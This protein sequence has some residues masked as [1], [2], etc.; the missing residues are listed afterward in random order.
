MLNYIQY[1]NFPTKIACIFVGVFLFMQVIG[2]LLEFKG[3]VVPECIKVRKYFA[4][5]KSERE[6]LQKIPAMFN[7]VETLL[8][9]VGSHYSSDNIS[10]RD[11]WI[12]S[13]NCKMDKNDRLIR[14]LT[15]KIDKNNADT[16]ALLIDSKRN[17]IIDFAARVVDE[18]APV[19]HEQFHRIFK[20]HKEYETIISDNG[21]TNGEVD[22]AYR[23]ISESYEKHLRNH[24]FIEDLR[25]YGA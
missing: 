8:E 24:S 13:V 17:T 3:K 22:V 9:D 23:I 4:R 15:E 2:E 11:K 12:D 18:D 6:L 10:M 5:R 14:D 20:L 25:G 19:T 1:L 7:R 21:L 16:L